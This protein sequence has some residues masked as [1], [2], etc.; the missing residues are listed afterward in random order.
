[1][2][3]LEF[4]VRIYHPELPDP[5]V[6]DPLTACSVSTYFGQMDAM[7]WTPEMGEH[8]S[9]IGENKQCP[10]DEVLA[11]EVRLQLLV[12]RT[13]ELRDKQNLERYQAKME[14]SNG[15]SAL[16]EP[17]PALF[18]LKPVETELQAIR[19]S[20]PPELQREGKYIWSRQVWNN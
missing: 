5:V 18:Y 16:R 12:H 15:A 13:I 11:L 19:D 2:F 3:P 1:M 9:I 14:A 20:I 8:L 4:R 17:L 6:K 7:R 10:Q